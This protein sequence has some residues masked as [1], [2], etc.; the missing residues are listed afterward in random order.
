MSKSYFIGLD[1]GTT[2]VKALL[3]DQKGNV[4]ATSFQP[5]NLYHPKPAWAEQDPQEWVCS[6]KNALSDLL[7]ISK[8]NPSVVNGIGI[9][10]QI[11]G[12][13]LIDS[14]GKPLRRAI[15]WMDRRAIKQCN[16]IKMKIP[17]EL[18]YEVTGLC[19]DPSHVAAKILWI[20]ENEW[21]IYSK[22]K[23]FL[24]PGD[25]ILYY[26]TGE[27]ATDYSNASSTM[28]LDI[29][30]KKWSKKI[31]DLLEIPVE[32][33]PCIKPAFKIIGTIKKDV[34]KYCGLDP[35][36]TIVVGGGDEEVGAVG[37]GVINP[38]DVVDITGTAEPICICVDKPVF[39]DKR[40][41]ECHVSVD[42]E[43]WLLENTGIVAGGLYRWFRD[44]FC[45]IE[46]EF[47]S[48]TNIDPY[49]ILNLEASKAPPG[50]DGLICLPFFSGSITP[51]WDAQARGVF[52]GLTLAHRKEHIARAILEG[53][54]YVLRDT[55]ERGEKL[56]IKIEKIVAAGGGAKGKL[57][58]QIK[59]DVT[60]KK[61]I[62]TMNEE[63]TAFG[64]ALL[65]EVGTGVYKNLS[66]AV[67]ETVKIYEEMQPIAT[68][69]NLY[70]RLYKI[71]LKLYYTLK[72]VFPEIS[73]YQEQIEK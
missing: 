14:E 63:V 50:S 69:Y 49:E 18:M 17:D 43:F 30:E 31:C 67:K 21:H 54:A 19:V 66:T 68:H 65:A 40:V 51:E 52:F 62:K 72:E 60:N 57:W 20:K 23:R 10:S 47:A 22:T 35:S 2:G 11:D 55:I 16:E 64:A 44:Q 46:T 5:Y 26:L 6:T 27:V 15:I 32:M 38:G 9:G 7:K 33:L 53:C 13:I 71:Y 61:I 3:C 25:Y 29:R 28:L 59:A 39:D 58:R 24:M 73:I 37:A 4:V 42:P 56:G 36:T 34:A 45:Q 12:V 8:V 70:N 41:L 1:L 48:K